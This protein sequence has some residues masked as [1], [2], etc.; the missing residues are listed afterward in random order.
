MHPRNRY[1][2]NPADFNKL[3]EIYPEFGQYLLPTSH[4]C[5]INFKDPKA[6]RELTISLLHHDFGLNIELPLDRLIPTITLRLNYIH[7]IEDL[8]QMLPSDVNQTTAVTT[9]IDI[10]QYYILLFYL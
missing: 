6:L 9:G 10:G 5:T 3:G 1:Y 7:W 2:G 4:G 8:L